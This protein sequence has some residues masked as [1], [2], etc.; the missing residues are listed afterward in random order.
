MNVSRTR[1]PYVK[2]A[3][4]KGGVHVGATRPLLE[5]LGRGPPIYISGASPPQWPTAR[6][7][8]RR[9]MPRH[10]TFW[11]ALSPCRYHPSPRPGRRKPVPWPR[12]GGPI[13]TQTGSAARH[14]RLRTSREQKRSLSS[15]FWLGRE[16]AA[17]RQR[18]AASGAGGAAGDLIQRVRLC[19]GGGGGRQ[20]C[21]AQYGHPARVARII[22][23]A[24]ICPRTA[25]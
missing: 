1:R 16:E 8:P 2:Y 6:S 22:A 4:Q 13:C 9:L 3:Q 25:L 15:L 23:Q 5:M 10:Q 21:T 7:C 20:N 14:T 24:Q 19:E 11:A 18:A 17:C 12:S